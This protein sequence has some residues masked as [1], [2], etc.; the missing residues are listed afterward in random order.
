MTLR[1]ATIALATL[2]T[3]MFA[4]S[5]DASQQALPAAARA[6]VAVP[7][8][9]E[10]MHEQYVE[11]FVESEGFGP[12]RIPR[13]KISK[14]VRRPRSVVVGNKPLS[15]KSFELIGIA[16]HEPPVVHRNHVHA[17]DPV[18][19]PQPAASQANPSGSPQNAVPQVPATR[20][21]TGFEESALA[22]FRK[23]GDLGQGMDGSDR[24]VIGPIRATQQC[25]KC[26][27]GTKSGDLMGAFTYRLAPQPEIFP[28]DVI[29][30]NVNQ[31]NV[32]ILGR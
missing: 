32:P 20:K 1:I 25:V 29:P 15:V 3:L 31:G 4:W 8:S 26:H 7:A 18:P 22:M 12:S 14:M 9:Y 24:I 11:A 23:G 13:P 17:M 10:D 30:S 5:E 21:L 19:K 2:G 16:K 28:G 27:E 6:A